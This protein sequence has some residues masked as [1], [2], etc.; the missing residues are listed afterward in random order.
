MCSEINGVSFYFIAAFIVLQRFAHVQEKS[1]QQ[2]YMGVAY[3]NSRLSLGV[4]L[5]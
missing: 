4:L 3:A 5:T 2:N 1:L